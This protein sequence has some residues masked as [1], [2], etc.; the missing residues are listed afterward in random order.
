MELSIIFVNWNALA[1]LRECL[2]SIYQHTQGL[3]FEVIVVD[4]ASP[5]GQV[6]TLYEQFPDISI[7]KS[8]ANLGFAGAN[9][10]GFR[11]AQGTYVLFLNPDT[12]LT[13]PAIPI[14]LEQIKSLPHAGII[15]CK[16]LNTDRTIQTSCIQ[17]FP[18]LLNQLF[19][20]EY[21]QLRWPHV[22]LWNI[23]PLFS[24]SREPSEVE[25]VSGACMLLSREA[26]VRA[27]GF[28]EDYFM[29]AEDIDLCFK[30]R[31]L[32]LHNYYVGQAELIHHGGK[33]TGQSNR[34]QWSTVMKLKAVE[35][36]CTKYHGRLY[37]TLYR[38]TMGGAAIARLSLL[39]L[40]QLFL[41]TAPRQA[42]IQRAR[43][44]WATVL[45]WS[46]GFAEG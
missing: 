41:R 5:E 34:N 15:G 14:L 4:N 28:S 43:S 19:D 30:V 46:L 33:S 31:R 18:T 37:G 40:A 39:L 26:F 3:S 38:G 21:L 35:K 45:K 2:A 6:D 11:H 12:Q 24:E 20:V 27:G 13:G 32:G 42:A 25:V 22:P 44:K 7:V 1:Y 16:L 17:T 8:K 9:N 36:F 10:L 29:Y 23:A